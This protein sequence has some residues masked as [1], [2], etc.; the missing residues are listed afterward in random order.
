MSSDWLNHLGLTILFS[1]SEF[2]LP[3]NMENSEQTEKTQIFS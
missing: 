2:E 3:P 1:H